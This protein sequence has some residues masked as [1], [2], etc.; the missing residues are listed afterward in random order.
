[1]LDALKLRPGSTVADLGAGVGYF[2][3][4]MARR[5]GP[6]GKV[7][8]IDL[9]PEMV[10]GVRERRQGVVLRL[11]VA[12]QVQVHGMPLPVSKSTAYA[13]DCAAHAIHTRYRES[14]RG[15]AGSTSQL[16][17]LWLEFRMVFG[18][19]SSVFGFQFSVR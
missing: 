14:A 4:R 16:I 8:A 2:S 9:Q 6:E 12:D 11:S 1:M 18:L 7:L 13:G 17:I 15:E 19:R 3:F 10:Q 5:V